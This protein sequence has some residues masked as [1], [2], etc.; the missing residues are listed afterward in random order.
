MN[1]LVASAIAETA[2]AKI[3]E[4]SRKG[5]ANEYDVQLAVL[6][7]ER[8]NRNLKV[9]GTLAGLASLY[10]V[11]SK[12]YRKL[13]AQQD[14]NK[15]NDLFDPRLLSYAESFYQTAADTIEA[16]LAPTYLAESE[17]KVIDTIRL[18]KNKHD[19]YKLHTAFGTRS[20]EKDWTN[21]WTGYSGNLTDW[22][23]SDMTAS[24]L[25]AITQHLNSIGI[26][27]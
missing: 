3:T 10:F 13:K 20:V 14:G 9:A 12:L 11:G 27:F 19:W 21:G 5:M 26:T 18:L 17:S 8:R 16:A 15:Y 2:K 25:K 7:R 4:S 1:P 6:K 23:V 24:N 22:L